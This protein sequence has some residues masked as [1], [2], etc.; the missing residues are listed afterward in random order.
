METRFELED[1]A[2]VQAINITDVDAQE[3]TTVPEIASNHLRE[4]RIGS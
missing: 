3:N 4:N 2:E 1:E